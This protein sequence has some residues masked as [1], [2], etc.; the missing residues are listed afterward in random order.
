MASAN[1]FAGSVANPTTTPAITISTSITGIIKGN[2]TAL[3]AA[4]SGT[5]YAPATTGS[6]ILKASSG[7]F[8]NAAAGTDYCAATSGSGVLKGSSG[9]TAAAVA[10]TDF[11]APG[12]ATDFTAQQN[13]ISQSLTDGASISW[14][15][16][17]QQNAHVTLGGNR[18]LA[19]PTNLKNGGTYILRV[20]QDATG[21][22]T[23]SYGSVYKWP[24]GVAPTLS[25]AANAIDILTFVSDGTNM[26]GNIL[27]A[28]A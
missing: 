9:N 5:D 11:V 1:G 22:R 3:S 27:K 28:F 6:S 8:A 21:S 19:N 23:L 20:V 7:G 14:N 17:S 15:L 25:T 12:T 4:V 18:A 10:G 26:Y 2:G 16:A 13:F 24:G